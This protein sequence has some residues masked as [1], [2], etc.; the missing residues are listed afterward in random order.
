M[1]F[2]KGLVFLL[3]PLSILLILLC[4]DTFVFS[5]N[6]HPFKWAITLFF[7]MLSFSVK[8]FLDYAYHYQP[9]KFQFYF[10]ATSIVRLLLSAFFFTILLLIGIDHQS[11]ISFVITFLIHYFLYLFFE[12]YFLLLKLR[13]KN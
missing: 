6:L 11:L 13:T 8:L 10:L 5:L 4:V 1:D 7:F 9:N 12:I 3:I 2:L